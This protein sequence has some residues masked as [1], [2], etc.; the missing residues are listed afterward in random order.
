MN[1]WT[2]PSDAELDMFLAEPLV[3]RGERL[4]AMQPHQ[5]IALA[6]AYS[7]LDGRPTHRILDSFA[8]WQQLYLN[9]L[10]AEATR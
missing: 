2:L 1:R 4:C 9:S 10:Q 6:V 7:R 3:R 8:S 5:R